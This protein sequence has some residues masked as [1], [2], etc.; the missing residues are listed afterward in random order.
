MSVC[1]HHPLVVSVSV[2]NVSHV[3][4]SQLVV[5]APVIN[6]VSV[7]DI[8]FKIGVSVAVITL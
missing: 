8:S 1:C 5:S 3:Y 7:A 2:I 4:W 6:I